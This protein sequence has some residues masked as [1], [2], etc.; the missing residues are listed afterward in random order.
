MKELII[1][2]CKATVHMWARVDQE[3]TLDLSSWILIDYWQGCCRAGREGRKE[4]HNGTWLGLAAWNSACSAVTSAPHWMWLLLLCVWLSFATICEGVSKYW[5]R[6]QVHSAS[7]NLACWGS[8][9]A[10]C[11]RSAVLKAHLDRGH[12]QKHI[13]FPCP[14]SSRIQFPNLILLTRRDPTQDHPDLL[15]FHQTYYIPNTVLSTLCILTCL[16]LIN[17]PIR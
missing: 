4:G 9:K 2:S 14:D 7:S 6:P 13:F 15:F 16:I 8:P 5:Q 11:L 1:C 10:L 3:Q 17:K 12:S